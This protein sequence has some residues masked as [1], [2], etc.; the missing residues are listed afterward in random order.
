MCLWQCLN[1]WGHLRARMVCGTKKVPQSHHS[2]TGHPINF[3][4]PSVSPFKGSLRNLCLCVR[5]R[6]TL[7][8]IHEFF[9]WLVTCFINIIPSL[10]SFLFP[11]SWYAS[12]YFAFPFTS[13]SFYIS[14]FTRLLRLCYI[15]NILLKHENFEN[16]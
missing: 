9:H 10:S 8:V 14:T 1:F 7:L 15:F 6:P 2:H 16:H 13:F 5:E 3:T 11:L 4:G 12:L